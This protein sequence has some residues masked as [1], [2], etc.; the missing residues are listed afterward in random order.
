MGETQEDFSA[1]MVRVIQTLVPTF[2]AEHVVMRAS[3]A[4]KYISLTCS[5]YV[6][7]QDQLDDIYRLLS[8]HPLVKFA[9]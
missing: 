9:L 4:G 3:S 8:A 7:S 6:S 2:T 5:V 1:T